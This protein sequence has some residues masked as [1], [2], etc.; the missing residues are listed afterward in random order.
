MRNFTL[1]GEELFRLPWSEKFC[2]Y[3][4][5]AEYGTSKVLQS[6][7]SGEFYVFDSYGK[8]FVYHYDAGGSLI[9]S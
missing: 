5:A 2:L 1:N 9:R 7:K 4:Q 3:S 6:P 8:D